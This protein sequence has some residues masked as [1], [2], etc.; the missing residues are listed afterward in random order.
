LDKLY[1]GA[2]HYD[3]FGEEFLSFAW[4]KQS[5]EVKRRVSSGRCVLMETTPLA[6]AALQR[7]VVNDGIEFAALMTSANPLSPSEPTVLYRLNPVHR[8]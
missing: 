1:P 8:P 4:D 3:P 6:K 2:I 5:A 7:F